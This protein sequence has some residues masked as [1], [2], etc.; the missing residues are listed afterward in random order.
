MPLSRRRWTAAEQRAL[1]AV[2]AGC[3]HD[4][5]PGEPVQS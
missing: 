1:P 3:Q 5:L 2:S 4:G